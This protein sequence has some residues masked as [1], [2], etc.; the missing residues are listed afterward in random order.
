MSEPN[1]S[2]WLKML[3]IIASKR[4]DEAEAEWACVMEQLGL[5]P[6]CFLGIHEAVRQGRWR[7]AENPGAYLKTAA[8]REQSRLTDGGERKPRGIR[9]I[10]GL[11]FAGEEITL[12]RDG[13]AGRSGGGLAEDGDRLS[14]EELLEHMEHRRSGGRAV[15][16]PDGIWRGAGG[17]VPGMG[18][19]DGARRRAQQAAELDIALSR[20]MAQRRK[21]PARH[22]GSQ[23]GPLDRYMKRIREMQAARGQ[24]EPHV[25]E[26]A[27]ERLR[28]DW[29]QWAQAA[30]LSDWEKKVVEYKMR[31]VGWRQAVAEQPDD[32]SRR[33][34]RAAWRKLERTGEAR[35]RENQNL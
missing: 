32:E 10:P 24:E 33:A 26:E 23:P 28:V 11:E 4:P 6:E 20:G 21:R 30:G 9:G 34:L 17:H 31:G 14:S 5:G 8:R 19:S 27:P 15:R 12:G 16:D 18:E 35:L 25:D 13:W 22:D 29:A 1:R 7:E 2:Q 3:E